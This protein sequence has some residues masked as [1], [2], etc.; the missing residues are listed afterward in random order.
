MAM[1][2]FRN[3]AVSSNEL[4]NRERGKIVLGKVRYRHTTE[5]L[6]VSG[7]IISM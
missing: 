4:L 6:A 2:E 5:A 1:R 3:A 7:L